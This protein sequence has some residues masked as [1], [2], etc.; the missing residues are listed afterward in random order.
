MLIAQAP[1]LPP[2]LKRGPVVKLLVVALLAEIAYALLNIS[3]MPVYLRDVRGFGELLV[4]VV[5]VSY[6]LSEALFKGPMG[7]L[8]DRYGCRKFMI[9][10][11]CI[12]LCTSIL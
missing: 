11:P 9:A 6:L 1:K 8:A 2:L 10:A 3:T 12:T 7:H 5:I 4:S